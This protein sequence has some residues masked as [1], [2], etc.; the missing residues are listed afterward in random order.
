M[1]REDVADG[2]RR[3]AAF[4]PVRTNQPVVARLVTA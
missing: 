3:I 2:S 1:T 4:V